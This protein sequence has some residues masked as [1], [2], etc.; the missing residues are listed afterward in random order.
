MGGRRSS[1]TSLLPERS[2][3]RAKHWMALAASNDRNRRLSFEFGMRLLQ[4]LKA[5]IR[6]GIAKV[7]EYRPQP[8]ELRSFLVWLD[9]WSMVAA[10]MLERDEGATL[11]PTT[12]RLRFDSFVRRQLCCRHGVAILF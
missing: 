8:L 4:P 7:R 12:N 2:G 10:V 5:A 9:G 6:R 11:D 3:K 1:A